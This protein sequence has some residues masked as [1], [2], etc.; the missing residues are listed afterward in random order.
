[1]VDDERPVGPVIVRRRLGHELRRLRESADLSLEAVATDME[2]SPSKLSRMENGLSPAKMWDVRNLLTLYKVADE[3]RR[4]ELV[5]WARASKE[6][7]WW[8]EDVAAAPAQLDYFFSLE[9]EAAAVM[10]YCTPVVPALLQT[11]AY[12][13]AHIAAILPGWTKSAIDRLVSAR[14][15]RQAVLRR[16]RDALRYTVVIDEGALHRRVGAPDVLRSQLEALLAPPRSVTVRILPFAAGPFRAITS[17][18]TIFVPR[19]PD[20]DPVVVNVEG[21][22]N[23]TYTERQE[24]VLEYRAA[25][26]TLLSSCLDHPESMAFIR[27]LAQAGH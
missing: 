21:A 7:A 5:E 3:S 2:M 20:V 11:R 9:A 12:A 17:P 4:D 19:L 6:P 26:D 27:S 25:F 22:L 14:L 24:D 16:R 23:D 18:F 8:Q 1:M 15:K 13:R 10:G